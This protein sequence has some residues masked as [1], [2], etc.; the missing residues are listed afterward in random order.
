MP[1][2]SRWEELASENER[3]V[4]PSDHHDCV[5]ASTA[6]DAV[7]QPRETRG[8]YVPARRPDDSDAPH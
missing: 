8:E 3:L 1:Y 7:C 5:P 2:Q 4:V 6:G